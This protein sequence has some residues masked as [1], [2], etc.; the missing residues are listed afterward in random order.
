MNPMALQSKHSY[1]KIIPTGIGSHIAA[2]KKEAAQ[3]ARLPTQTDYSGRLKA[4]S[5]TRPW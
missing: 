4:V 5:A 2:R 1:M 3:G